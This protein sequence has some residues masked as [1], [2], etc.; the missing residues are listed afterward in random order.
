MITP[1]EQ[2]DLDCL[3]GAYAVINAAKLIT[4]KISTHDYQDILLSILRQQIRRKKSI[5]FIIHGLDQTKLARILQYIVCPELG[6]MY[7]RPFK[8]RLKVSVDEFWQTLS[9]F[10]NKDRR[11]AIICFENRR[12]D[13]HWTVVEFITEKRLYIFDSVG[14][15]TINRSH[16]TTTKMTKETPVLIDFTATF[17]L[18]GK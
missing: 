4:K 7:W 2:G 13:G 15:K 11:C 18:E 3:C 8:R 9:D 10:L 1:Y 6:M 14:R 5:F 16:C 17:L 12:Y